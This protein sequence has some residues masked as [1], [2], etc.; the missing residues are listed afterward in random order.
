MLFT[1]ACGLPLNYSFTRTILDFSHQLT[2]CLRFPHSH[3]DQA[4]QIS[5]TASNCKCD[6]ASIP[7]LHGTFRLICL[8]SQPHSHHR[9]ILRVVR[10][11][12]CLPVSLL[13]GLGLSQRDTQLS[14]DS[15]HWPGHDHYRVLGQAG[16]LYAPRIATHHETKDLTWT[17]EHM[18][19]YLVFFRSS[20]EVMQS[21]YRGSASPDG[22]D[23]PS[24]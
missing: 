15:T 4:F 18:C 6:K 7:T 2:G 8:L 20:R 9:L 14:D 21:G 19:C 1:Y 24:M 12:P 5:M 22:L 23:P 16:A 17:S 3:E 11:H 13:V 10:R